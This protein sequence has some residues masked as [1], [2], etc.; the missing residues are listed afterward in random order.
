ML[1]SLIS[2]GL[3]VTHGCENRYN[4]YRWKE[5]GC[6][7]ACMLERGANSLLSELFRKD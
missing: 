3:T 1:K 4:Y 6:P 5:I 7:F 2:K